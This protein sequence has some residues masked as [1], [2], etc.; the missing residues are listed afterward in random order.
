M[1]PVR[2]PPLRG[3]SCRDAGRNKALLLQ[4]P[5]ADGSLI[6]LASF[7]KIRP[8]SAYRCALSSS[9]D[10]AAVPKRTS[11]EV[12]SRE[13]VERLPRLRVCAHSTNPSQRRVAEPDIRRVMTPVWNS[14]ATGPGDSLDL[15]PASGGIT[16]GVG[17]RRKRMKRLGEEGGNTGGEVCFRHRKKRSGCVC[18]APD[19]VQLCG[20][21][22]VLARAVKIRPHDRWTTWPWVPPP[23]PPSPP[24]YKRKL[25]AKVQPPGKPDPV[26]QKGGTEKSI[27]AG[28]REVEVSATEGAPVEGYELQLAEVCLLDGLSE[29]KRRDVGLALSY[30]VHGLMADTQVHM[31]VRAYNCAGAGAWSE[32]AVLQS[33]EA[34]ERILRPITE[35]PAAWRTVDLDDL[36]KEDEKQKAIPTVKNWEAVLAAMATHSAVIKVSRPSLYGSPSAHARPTPPDNSPPSPTSP[37]RRSHSA[38]TS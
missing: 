23:R 15:Q 13:A 30:T 1:P 28:W 33:M 16:P 22:T 25:R 32:V 14:L 24:P 7:L 17:K 27:V 20:K 4:V 38:T 6:P 8:E 12:K 19:G 29:S 5:L 37:A 9:L 11:P 2:M 31:Q 34:E 36:L 35:I 21:H 26:F 3:V 18:V 10:I